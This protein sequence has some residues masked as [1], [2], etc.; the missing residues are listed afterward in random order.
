MVP[1]RK[2]TNQI[3]CLLDGDGRGANDEG[4]YWCAA[5][6]NWCL[7]SAVRQSRNHGLVSKWKTWGTRIEEPVQGAIL[8]KKRGND[9][10]G[11]IAFVD[12]VN[13]QWKMLGGNQ[14]SGGRGTVTSA[15]YPSKSAL[16]ALIWPQGV[17]L[18]P[19][20]Q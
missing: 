10:W 4:F 11:H 6:V 14:T 9:S 17:E 18:P 20:L 19:Q 16:T 8:I 7:R 15:A 1:N 5:F 3:K 2:P 12:Q 13:G